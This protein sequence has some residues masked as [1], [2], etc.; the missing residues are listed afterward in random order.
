MQK[1]G[2]LTCKIQDLTNKR[3]VLSK[4]ALKSLNKTDLAKLT[5]TL[6]IANKELSKMSSNSIGLDSDKTGFTIIQKTSLNTNGVVVESINPFSYW[7]WSVEWW[8][9]RLFF[10]SSCINNMKS[11]VLTYSAGAGAGAAAATYLTSLA[12]VSGPAGVLIGALVAYQAF[13]FY[14]HLVNNN[15]GYGVYADSYFYQDPIPT[16]FKYYTAPGSSI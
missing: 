16:A 3:F 15:Q 2:N 6:K 10:S 4:D 11:Y 14:D 5:S 12:G 13:Y 7:D 8:G 9:K 1:W